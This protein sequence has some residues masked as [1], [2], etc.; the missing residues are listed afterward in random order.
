MKLKTRQDFRARRHR[1][2]RRKINGSASCPRLAIMVSNRAIQAQFIDDEAAVTLV[3]MTSQGAETGSKNV[4]AAKTLGT[5]I[6]ALAKER[7]I[8]RFVV[9]R[10]GFAYRGR[11]KAVVEGA[12][13]AGLTNTKEAK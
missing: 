7:G 11:V 10:G 12:L 6:G 4:A 13:E 1:R 9:D 8:L 3:G 5:R 2:I